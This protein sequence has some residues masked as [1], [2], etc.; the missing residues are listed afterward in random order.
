MG[1]HYDKNFLK[2]AG[3]QARCDKK[4]KT[5]INESTVNRIRRRSDIRI[6]K[7][8]L[9]RPNCDFYRHLLQCKDMASV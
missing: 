9:I 5:E 7:N 8:R 4:R 3:D 2:K 6:Y 1:K